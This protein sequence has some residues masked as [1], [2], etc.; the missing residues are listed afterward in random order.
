MSTTSASCGRGC[1]RRDNS[2]HGSTHNGTD[3]GSGGYQ[4][5][6]THLRK[7]EPS[8]MST[9]SISTICEVGTTV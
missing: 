7:T 6:T 4:D 3:H 1:S 9:L 8:R 2:A 5:A